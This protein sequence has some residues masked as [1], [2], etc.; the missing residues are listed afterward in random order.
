MASHLEIELY[1]KRLDIEKDCDASGDNQVAIVNENRPLTPDDYTVKVIFN[2]N[3]VVSG[4]SNKDGFIKYPKFLQHMRTFMA[5]DS[6]LA[7]LLQTQ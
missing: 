6:E 1:K 4:I 5:T 2:G 7:K 3:T